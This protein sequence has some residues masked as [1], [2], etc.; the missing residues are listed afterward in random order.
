MVSEKTIFMFWKYIP[1]SSFLSP[2]EKKEV[3]FL[4]NK[5]EFQSPK[6]DLSQVWLNLVQWFRRRFEKIIDGRRAIGKNHLN[7]PLR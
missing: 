5:N 2:K 3:V 6:V 7:F 4:L 1:A